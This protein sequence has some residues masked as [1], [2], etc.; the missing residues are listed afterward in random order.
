MAITTEKL[1]FSALEVVDRPKREAQAEVAQQLL[2]LVESHPQVG[3]W[4]LCLCTPVVW[5]RL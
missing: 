3:G 2:R 4:L 1:K 5:A